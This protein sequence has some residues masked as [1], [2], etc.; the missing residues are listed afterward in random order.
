MPQDT[1]APFE[2]EARID[3]RALLSMLQRHQWLILGTVLI[4]VATALLVTLQLR[5]QFT[6]TTMVVVDNRDSQMLGFEPGIADGV[7]AN[8]QVD[9]EVEIARSAKVGERAAA[10]LGIAGWPEFRAGAS[11]GFMI[12]SL[13]GFASPRPSATA[14]AIAFSDLPQTEQARLVAA[15]MQRVQIRRVGLTSVISISASAYDPETSAKMANAVA[16]AYLTEQIAAKVDSNERAASF[17]RERVDSLA[18][19]IGTGE[20]QIDDFVNKTLGQLGSPEARDLLQRMSRESQ[21]Q[22]ADS[23]ALAALQSALSAND[24]DQLVALAGEDATSLAHQR[25]VLVA[26]VSGTNDPA[27]LA[28]AQKN[29]DALN[30][31]IKAAAEQ[32]SS[33]LQD[34]L[35]ASQSRSA[36]VRKQIQDTVGQLQLPQDVSV[37]LFRLQRD[38]ETRRT[39]YDT[40]LTKL[41]QV[42]QQTD[43]TVPDSRVIASATPPVDPS[44]PPF[45]LILAG[46][47]IFSLGA[48]IGL[49]F[50]R[51]H[52]IGGITSVE[53]FE[54][55]AGIPVIAAVPRYVGTEGNDRPDLAIIAEPLSAFAESIRRVRMGVDVY[56]PRSKRCIFVTSSLPADGKTTIALALARHFAVTG[57]ST[58]L[59]DADLRHPSIHR[60]LNENVDQGMLGFLA[61]SQDAGTDQLTM[62]REAATG[63]HY[64][65]G[66]EASAIATDSLLMSTR[67]D[68]LMAFARDRYD[69]VIV[70]TPPVGLVV[71][72][73]IVARHCDLGLFIVKHAAT[74]QHAVRAALRDLTRRVD[75]PICGVLNRIERGDG[76]RYGY[77][78]DYQGYYR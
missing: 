62:V 16:D 66:A 32:R 54:N 52:Y 8:S 64:V 9:T 72:A 36:D 24:Y 17:L 56:G 28:A 51:E 7:G 47:F 33:A 74:G 46:S 39:L 27:R 42:E 38:A 71:D 68:E 25:Q 60:L 4:I 22:Q 49:A 48:G 78:R 69:V 6:A 70:D 63:A 45:K 75:L 30:Q 77:G 3:V 76:Y 43:F 35:S 2:G 53:Q 1:A 55:L 23:G 67:F 21:Q 11:I 34:D 57:T 44:F 13:F 73:T 65:L 41:R 59:I 37:E 40:F 61:Q 12:R 20:Q 50:L 14:P 29:L 5:Q 10:A 58:L 31:E 15:L 18:N 26:Q 19:D